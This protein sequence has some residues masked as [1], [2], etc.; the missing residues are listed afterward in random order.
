MKTITSVS[1][2]RTSAYLAANYPSDYNLFALVR[3]EDEN[4]RFP[5]EK[6][7]RLVEDKIQAPFIGTAEDD[8]I[9][10][11]MLDLEQYLGRPINWV[12]G[13]TFDHIIHKV[14]HGYLPN[15]ARRY[16]TQ[17][18]KLAPM[19]YWWQANINEPIEMRIGFRSNELNRAN[20]M[21]ERVNEDGLLSF[22]GIVGKKGNKNKWANVYW[23]KPSFPLI[24]DGILKH[25]ISKYWMGKSVRFADYNNCV[26]CFH[27]SPL[28][29]AKMFDQHPNKMQWFMDQEGKQRGVGAW[30]DDIKYSEIQKMKIQRTLS[31]DDLGGCASGY[32]EVA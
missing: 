13:N 25:D 21:I 9:I 20:R 7:R 15:I 14:N 30:K 12:T 8:M 22:K 3:I 5:D 24:E 18:M 28:F 11:T 16:C 4:C 1:G 19:F 32:C 2:G 27:R 26:G 10:Y 31:F 23:Q 6:I 17:M 29:L